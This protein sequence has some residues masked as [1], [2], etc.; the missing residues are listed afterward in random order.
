MKKSYQHTISTTVKCSGI[1]VHSGKVVNMVFKPDLPNTGITFVRTDVTNKDNRIKADFKNV[2]KTNL[3][4]TLVNESGTEI[5][6]VEHLMS[7]IWG[8]DIDNLIVEVDNIEVPILDG[9][10][11][12]FIFLANCAGIEKQNEYRKFLKINKK[13]TVSNESN[14]TS[15]SIEPDNDFS[16]DFSIEF[17]NKV[18]GK[19]IFSYQSNKSDFKSSISR[20]R[21]F[22]LAEEIEHLRN[23]GLA[24][25][26]SLNNAIVVDKDK[27]LNPDGLRFDDEFVRHKI[28]D[29][30]GDLYLCGL[31]IL[32]KYSGNKSG[33]DLNNKLLREVFSDKANYEIL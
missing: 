31:P 8:A 10:S 21:T 23:N 17:P 3:G 13:I 7:G 30:I 33:H 27:V 5:A 20:A 25:G 4:T 12:P 29:A 19:Q 2:H 22:G 28:L 14:T 11:E 6:T 9:S 24:L 26:G 18:I 16:V 15:C 1:G 32:G